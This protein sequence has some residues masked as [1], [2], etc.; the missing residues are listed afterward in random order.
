M[1]VSVDVLQ[2]DGKE[3]ASQLENAADFEISFVLP[4][5]E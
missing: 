1:S 2:A 4:K 5:I 3:L